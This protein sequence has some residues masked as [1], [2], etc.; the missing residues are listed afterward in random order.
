MG[1]HFQ[2]M[3]VSFSIFLSLLIAI[4][5][6]ASLLEGTSR[7]NL[8]LPPLI[9]QTSIPYNRIPFRTTLEDATQDALHIY[10]D[11]RLMK[12]EATTG[13]EGAVTRPALLT[14]IRLIFAIP[15]QVPYRTLTVQMTPR[16]GRWEEPRLSQM[17]P[18]ENCQ[19]IDLDRNLG[20]DIREA[21]EL[22]KQGGFRQKYLAVDLLM[23]IGRGEV[24]YLFQM[25][26]GPQGTPDVV[27]VGSR[28]GYISATFYELGAENEIYGEGLLQG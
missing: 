3:Q 7:L 27:M 6:K 28:S 17:E 9:N 5:A 11:A 24:V 8:T 10:P 20:M 15:H 26:L 19:S 23:P 4:S 14:D 25:D 13:S 22:I 12:I 18:P 2:T 21:D 1:R 16:W